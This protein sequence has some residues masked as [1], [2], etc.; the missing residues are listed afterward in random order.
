MCQ[1]DVQRAVYSSIRARGVPA[2]FMPLRYN[3]VGLAH[4]TCANDPPHAPLWCVWS[5]AWH[6]CFVIRSPLKHEAAT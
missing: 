6:A 1:A 2:I 5:V 4:I 3:V